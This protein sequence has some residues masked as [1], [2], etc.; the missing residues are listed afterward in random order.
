MDEKKEK[1]RWKRKRRW[2]D[3][4]GC[5]LDGTVH[6]FWKIVLLLTVRK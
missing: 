1:D 5:K 3:K 2:T 6:R 4:R